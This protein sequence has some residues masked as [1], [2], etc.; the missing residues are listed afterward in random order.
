MLVSQGVVIDS[1]RH[2]ATLDGKPLDLTPN[3]FALLTAMLRRPGRVYSC[4]GAD[5]GGAWAGI[6]LCWSELSTFTSVR[7]AKRLAQRPDWWKLFAASVIDFETRL[8]Q[9]RPAKNRPTHTTT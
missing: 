5:P 3:E 9:N 6:P 1:E 7:F 8:P 2:R 4:A